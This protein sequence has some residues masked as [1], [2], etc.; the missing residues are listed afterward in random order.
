M[1]KYLNSAGIAFLTQRNL[2]LP[3]L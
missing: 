1:A 2:K 3:S